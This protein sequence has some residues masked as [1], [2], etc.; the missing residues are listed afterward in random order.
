[1]LTV[2]PLDHAETREQVPDLT[3]TLVLLMTMHYKWNR[4][5]QISKRKNKRKHSFEDLE[6][7]RFPIRYPY[8][9]AIYLV[10]TTILRF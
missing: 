4:R 10:I 8:L 2:S 6:V 9:L 7:V 1:M 3:L 5:I